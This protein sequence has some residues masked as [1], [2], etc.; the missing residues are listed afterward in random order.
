MLDT[1]I[2]QVLAVGLTVSQLFNLPPEKFKMQ[3]HPQTDQAEVVEIL[4]GGCQLFEKEFADEMKEEDVTFDDLFSLFV[5]NAESQVEQAKEI[6]QSPLPANVAA[7]SVP[8]VDPNATARKD[9]LSQLLARLDPGAFRIAYGYFCKSEVGKDLTRL[10]IPQAIELY[11]K[12]LANLP[13]ANAIK[14]VKL[15]QASQIYDING[16]RFAEVYKDRNR[17]YDI[18]IAELPKYVPQAF[19]ALEDKTFYKHNGLDIRGIARA[20]ANNM[21]K[22]MTGSEGKLVQGGSTITQQVI[23]N[24][25]LTDDVK[26]ERKIAEMVLA[27]RIETIL[28]KDQILEL[29]LNRIFMGRACWGIECG[30]RAYFGKSAK[31]LSVAEAALLAGLVQGPNYNHTERQPKRA[32][33]RRNE[34]LNAMKAQGYIDAATYNEA[35]K[36]DD[37]AKM[38][39]AYEPPRRKGGYAFIDQ[40]NRQVKEITG[41]ESLVDHSF[42]VHTSLHPPLQKAAEMALQKGLFEFD[43]RAG[44]TGWNGATDSLANAIARNDSKWQ[45]EFPKVI[46]KLY[47]LHWPLAVVIRAGKSVRVALQDGREA[48]LVRFSKDRPK[49]L[50]NV[51]ASLKQYDLINVEMREGK[52]KGTWIAEPR[53][54]TRIQGSAVVLENKTG[55]VLAMT[56]G[57]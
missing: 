21:M 47:D 54:G 7:E 57:V 14:D 35:I 25:M 18:S 1:L 36:I 34:A 52:K 46:P 5:E 24:V 42:K 12:S 17:R 15:L 11:N 9:V 4:K 30:A 8:S 27:R 43:I 56:G 41:S 40:I 32:L 44:K 51:I 26:V 22:K 53:F 33:G 39:T 55:R 38:V 23:K 49:A 2:V 50:Q 28:T 20:F 31:H 29:Y 10:H 45:D 6:I 48:D 16:D 13:D 37:V 19:V 3:F